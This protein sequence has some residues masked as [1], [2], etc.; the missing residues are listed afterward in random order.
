MLLLLVQRKLVVLCV[1]LR[2]VVQIGSCVVELRIQL[3][4]GH[5][6][7]RFKRIV[8]EHVLRLVDH[9]P[10][11]APCGGRLQRGDAHIGGVID[12]R[13]RRTNATQSLRCAI[14]RGTGAHTRVG[15][16][17][18]GGLVSGRLLHTRRL[19]AVLQRFKGFDFS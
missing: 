19:V 15:D 1:T 7:Q 10:A 6:R 9:V 3:R 14:Q 13:L 2:L 16:I 5:V 11:I 17:V 8:R 18:R 4:L 12:A